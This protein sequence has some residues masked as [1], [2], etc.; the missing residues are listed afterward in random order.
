MR[1]LSCG[2]FGEWGRYNPVVIPFRILV[3]AKVSIDLSRRQL[4]DLPKLFHKR[5]LPET[6]EVTSEKKICFTSNSQ[7]TNTANFLFFLS[8]L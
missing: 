3:C 5:Q 1:V 4:K 8:G 2:M 7:S 6:K